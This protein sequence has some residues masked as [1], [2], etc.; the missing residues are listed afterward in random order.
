MLSSLQTQRRSNQ[1]KTGGR[2]SA[3]RLFVGT[4]VVIGLY[5]AGAQIAAAGN[6]SPQ[7]I[8]V[9][10][11]A[12]TYRVEAR[13]SVPQPA[14]AALAVLTD[15]ERIP[16]FLPDVRRSTVVQRTGGQAVLE[17][18]ASPR[19]MMF[20]RRVHLVLEV[21]E[22]PSAIRFRDR[23][24]TSFS[25]YEGSWQ[26]RDEGGG[27]T[28]TYRLEAKPSFAVPQFVLKRLLKRDAAQMIER[29]RAEIAARS[30]E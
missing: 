22:E 24:G 14:S 27:A 29:L 11:D 1:A 4:M 10:E 13:F 3:R 20:S 7:D 30:S 21:D 16:R 25:R 17:Q 23:C 26:V 28:I 15:Y 8:T 6:G 2:G 5:Q 12:G 18:E 9:R 19:F